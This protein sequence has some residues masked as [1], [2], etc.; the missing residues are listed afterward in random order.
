MRRNHVPQRTC[1]ACRAKGPKAEF[2]RVVR[3]KQAEYL[4]DPSPRVGGRGA[5][6]CRQASCWQKG[7][8]GGALARGL[9]GAATAESVAALAEWARGEFREP[10]GPA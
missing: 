3:T 7:L 6:L 2:V 8:H 5:Y 4:A 10:P 1:V 9:R